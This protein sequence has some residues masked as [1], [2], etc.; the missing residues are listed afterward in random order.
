MFKFHQCLWLHTMES[1]KSLTNPD[2][3]VLSQL[4]QSESS[5]LWLVLWCSLLHCLLIHFPWTELVPVHRKAFVV[6]VWFCATASLRVGSGLLV[7]SCKFSWVTLEI[8]ELS[9][10]IASSSTRN[11]CSPERFA[12]ESCWRGALDKVSAMTCCAP[13]LYFTTKDHRW[14]L[15]RMAWSRRG[16]L[17]RGFLKILSSCW[18]SVSTVISDFP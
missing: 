13:F 1:S 14:S 6:V 17:L 16:A 9:K 4:C 12:L 8:P 5:L 7:C 2:G 10:A 18:W 3:L 11:I 15:M